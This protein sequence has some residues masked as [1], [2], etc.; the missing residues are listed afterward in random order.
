MT[1][2]G[3]V[4]YY[5]GMEFLYT[6]KSIVLHQMKYCIEV[7][8][9]F[10]VIDCKPAITLAEVNEKLN[11]NTDGKEVDA[12]M[13]KQLLVLWDI[14]VTLGLIYVMQLG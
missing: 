3:K 7:L 2:L 4:I 1:N 14:F 8:K 12:T 10:K 6:S 11:A 5:L 9:R 13:F